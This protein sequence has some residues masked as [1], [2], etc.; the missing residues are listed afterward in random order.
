MLFDQFNHKGS[1]PFA[2]RGDELR[3]NGA[4]GSH[5]Q[6]LLAKAKWV[7][8]GTGGGYSGI[9]ASGSTNVILRLSERNLLGSWSTGLTP[10]I[11]LKFLIDKRDSQNIQAGH[12]FTQ[13]NSWNFFEEDFHTRVTPFDPVTQKAWVDTIYKKMVSG[14]PYPFAFSTSAIATTENNGTWLKQSK[15]KSPY[16]LKFVPAKD[17]AIPATKQTDSATGKDVNWYDQVKKATKSGD[18]L[19]KVSALDRPDGTWTH[20]ANV[21]LE[22]ALTTSE[23]GDN[24]MFF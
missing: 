13:S 24:R 15:V 8:V 6:G 11:A 10:A 22:S 16:E 2:H 1:T 17:F 5:A 9:Y 20:I 7:P 19:F 3:F 14:N 23:F 18:T 12:S 21:V 4:R